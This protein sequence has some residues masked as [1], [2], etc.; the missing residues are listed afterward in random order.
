MSR[1]YVPRT[2]NQG[3]KLNGT[4]AIPELTEEGSRESLGSKLAI[5][6]GGL[7]ANC[8]VQCVGSE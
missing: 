1:Y 6:V 8:Q 3:D 7:Q 4:A 5:M 2:M